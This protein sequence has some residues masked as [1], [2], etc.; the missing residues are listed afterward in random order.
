MLEKFLLRRPDSEDMQDV[1]DLMRRCD[2]R[3]IGFPDLDMAD[4]QYEWRKINL[5]RDAWI[6][7][8]SKGNLKG[9][10]AVLPWDMGKR[11]VICDDPG[12]EETDLYLG[13][14]ILC[15]KRAVN[16]LKERENPDKRQVAAHATDSA[17]Y[18][19]EILV[20]A[21]YSLKKYIFNMHI[22]LTKELPDVK[23]PSGIVMRTTRTGH[24]EQ[25]LHGL[26]Q[27]AFDWKEREA[28]P[29]DEWLEFMMRPEIYHEDLWFLAEQN[30]KLAGACLGF[31]YENM[32]WIKQ[33]AVAKPYRGMDLGRGLLQQAFH[34]F[35]RRGYEK[36]GLSVESENNKACQFYE[37]AGMFK[38]VQ[39]DEFI[40]LIPQ[41]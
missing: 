41:A 40:K 35:K 12:T 26:I 33:L 18:Q 20:E 39:L 6:A 10:G 19:K 25:V 17:E 23:M 15:E 14:L 30:G 38:A 24:D 28:Q 27:Q 31:A 29:F 21:G 22:D 3:D 36:A 9:Y 7:I 32:G 11:V 1:L 2:N 8:N 16:M 37:R 13:L 4:L 34:A 5:Y